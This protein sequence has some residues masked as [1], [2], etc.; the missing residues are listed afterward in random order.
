M[1]RLS[2]DSHFRF[3]SA[4]H[5]VAGFRRK[6]THT[7]TRH[8]VTSDTDF[9]IVNVSGPI[10]EYYATAIQVC[11]QPL[12]WDHCKRKSTIHAKE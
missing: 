1:S 8:R 3:D 12:R 6:L 7:S 2:I 10:L 9:A 4:A 5:A 11:E